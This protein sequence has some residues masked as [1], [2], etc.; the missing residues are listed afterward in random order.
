MTLART[1]LE[2][3]PEGYYLDIDEIIED[4]D[5]HWI[6]TQDI[7]DEGRWINVYSQIFKFTDN[8]YLEF[9]WTRG[10]TEY[11]DGGEHASVQAFLVE[12]AEV[13]VVKYFRVTE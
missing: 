12:P 9:V 1:F 6:G 4:A 11:Q 7:V 13:T 8:S 10:K 5:G 3:M 2:S